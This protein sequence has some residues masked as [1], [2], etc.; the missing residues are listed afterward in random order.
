MTKNIIFALLLAFSLPA[1]AH[2]DNIDY[3]LRRL[4]AAVGAALQIN[5]RL[6][7]ENEQAKAEIK[8]LK[9]RVRAVEFLFDQS[10]RQCWELRDRK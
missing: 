4:E 8:Q 7:E 2:G 9:E 10:N 5:V 3:R 1:H 6:A